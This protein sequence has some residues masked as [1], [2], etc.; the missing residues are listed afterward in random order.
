MGAALVSM[1]IG[2]MPFL[3]FISIDAHD[4]GDELSLVVGSSVTQA[5][6]SVSSL[7][8]SFY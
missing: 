8:L 3:S 2:K 7:F 1:R 6:I 4:N 5:A